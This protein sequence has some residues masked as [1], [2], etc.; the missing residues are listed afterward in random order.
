MGRAGK[1]VS[2]MF[3]KTL[4]SVEHKNVIGGADLCLCRHC[5]RSCETCEFM[6]L[7]ESWYGSGFV[8]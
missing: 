2:K 6:P 1:F 4:S 7:L 3:A 5:F 8:F